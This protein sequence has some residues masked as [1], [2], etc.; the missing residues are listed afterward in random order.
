MA[1]AVFKARAEYQRVTMFRAIIVPR[2]LDI[3]SKIMP[4]ASLQSQR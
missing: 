1:Q 4:G 2:I 3:R